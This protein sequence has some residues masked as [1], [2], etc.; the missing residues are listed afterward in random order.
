MNAG[1]PRQRLRRLRYNATL[2]SMLAGVRLHASELIA[3]I[4]VHEALARRRPIPSMPGQFQRPV[5]D[6]ADFAASLFEKGIRAV[7]LF[8]IP[9]EKD[10]S[11]SGAWAEDGAVQQAIGAIKSA[12]PEQLVIADTCLCEYTDH[13]HCGP[14]VEL[15]DGR[16]EVDNDAALVGL[17]RTA[18]SQAQAGADVVAPSA[19]MDGQVAAIRTALDAA[20]FQRTPILAYAVKF[21]SSLYGP[22]REAA[23]SAPKSGDRRSYQMD[24]LAPKQVLPEARADLAEGADMIMVKPAGA[25]L[26]VI[27]EVAKKIDAPL[28]AYQVSGEYSMVRLAGAAGAIDERRVAIELTSAIKRAGADLIITYFAEALAGWL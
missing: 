10:P 5:A 12:V 21:A 4:F 11:G 15:P 1:Y 13:G 22:F 23:E 16:Q 28:V 26:D 2:R 14:L 9:V 24:P 19:M 27:A 18:L 8:G 17:T 6:A 20:G 7:L 25:Y 3:P